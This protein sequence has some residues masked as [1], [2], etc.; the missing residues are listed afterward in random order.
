MDH[1][2]LCARV[3]ASGHERIPAGQEAFAGGPAPF[4]PDTRSLAR[5]PRFTVVAFAWTFNFRYP[6]G[7]TLLVIWAL[8]VSMLSLAALVLP[9]RWIAVVGLLLIAGHNAFDGVSPESFGVWAPLWNALCADP[10]PSCTR[11]AR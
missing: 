5:R 4:S 11:A 2:F 1:A 8:G 3:H 10:P 6:F 9:L 7:F